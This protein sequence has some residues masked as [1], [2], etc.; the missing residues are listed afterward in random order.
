MPH[1]V[2]G[3][4]AAAVL[5]GLASVPSVRAQDDLAPPPSD[6]RPRVPTRA[7]FAHTGGLSLVLTSS[8]LG[9]AAVRSE[10]IGGPVALT[11]EAGI[12]GI[13]DERETKYAGL[14]GTAIQAKRTFLVAVP[15][16]AG[17]SVRL[18]EDAIEPNVRPYVSVAAGP[19]VGWAYPYFRDCNANG[20]LDAS[21]D[22]NA[23]GTIETGEGERTLGFFEAQRRGRPLLGLG[24]VAGIGAH[25]GWGRRVTGLR[26]ATRVDVFPTGVALLEAR[27]RGRQRVF[28]SP[29]VSLTF[30]RLR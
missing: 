15:L 16:R 21:V 10:H 29:E 30:G 26:L 24:G 7:A 6:A 5:V 28:A 11:L 13:R 25:V 22:C 23:D 8:G 20:N 9:A 18:F 17:I 3:R 19:T 4:V 14:G 12:G 1:V 2:A 27:V